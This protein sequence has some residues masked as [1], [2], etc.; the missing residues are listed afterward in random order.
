[1]KLA[2]IETIGI[3]GLADATYPMGEAGGVPSPLVVVT[4]PPAAG[5]TT[6][7]ESVA[8][9]AARLGNAGP[10]PDPVQVLRIGAAVGAVRSAWW[11]DDDER[12]YGGL[13]ERVTRAQVSFERGGIAN[14]DA[15]PGLLA[16]MSRYDHTPDISKVVLFPARRIGE[17]ASPAISDFEAS[18]R[19]LRVST[20]TS[21][22]AGLQRALAAAQKDAKVWESARALYAGG[23]ERR[24]TDRDF[25]SRRRERTALPALALRAQRVRL[26]VVD[27]AHGSRAIRPPRRHAR[28][29]AASGSSRALDQRDARAHAGRAMDRSFA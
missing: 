8:F 15:D 5:S 28:S 25:H 6:F 20:A 18:Q 4:G 10:P 14:G 29:R 22:Y 16:L 24:R 9:T 13:A 21:K 27:R 2:E 1:L 3:R 12:R 11:V 23:R 19:M 26:C 7:L 17:E